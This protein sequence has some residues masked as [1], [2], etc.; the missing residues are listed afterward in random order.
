[1]FNNDIKQKM[2]NKSIDI[3]EYN[4]NQRKILKLEMVKEKEG[5][6]LIKVNHMKKINKKKNI[7]LNI[8]KLKAKTIDN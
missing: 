6:K 7:L 5:I 3:T 4:E 2:N 8:Y 1:M